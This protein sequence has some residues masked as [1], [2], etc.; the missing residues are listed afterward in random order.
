VI[1][2]NI[3]DLDKRLHL[4]RQSRY[5]QAEPLHRRALQVREQYLGASHPDTAESL[6]GLAQLCQHQGKHEQAEA[7]YQRVLHIQERRLGPDHP[8]TENT[9]LAYAAFLRSRERDESATVLDTGDKP[10]TEEGHE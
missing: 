1:W 10:S 9:H 6:R 2:K 5:E 3:I 7:L 4:H 8:E